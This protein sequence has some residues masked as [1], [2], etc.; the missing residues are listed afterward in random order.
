MS[1]Y[2]IWSNEHRA[3]WRP[4]SMGYTHDIASAGRYS[5]EEAIRYCSGS[6]P[7]REVDAP[8]PEL[9]ILEDDL[10]EIAKHG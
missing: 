1:D 5:R 9:P 8:P 2:L 10:L 6:F 7:F 3:W 4:G